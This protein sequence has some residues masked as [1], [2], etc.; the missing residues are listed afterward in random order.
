MQLTRVRANERAEPSEP[1]KGCKL[2]DLMPVG[3]RQSERHGCN[4]M[5]GGSSTLPAPPLYPAFKILDQP[6]NKTPH[7]TKKFYGID[8]Q[9]CEMWWG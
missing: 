6:N 5:Q 2:Y 1:R 7:I 9:P 8:K 3:Y 4:L